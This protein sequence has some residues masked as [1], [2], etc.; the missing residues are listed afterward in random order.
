MNQKS[1]IG[2]NIKIAKENLE[3]G[4]LVAIPTETVYGLAANAFDIKAVAKI[5]EAKNRPT[6]DP[7][8]VH[9][10]NIDKIKSWT[11][12]FPSWA[13]ELGKHF[14]AGALTLLLPRK[15]IIPDLVTSGLPHVAVRIPNHSLTLELLKSL[16]FPLAAPSA[17]P[18]GYISPT[19]ANHV[20]EQLGKKVSYI[21]DGGNCKI[22]VESTI[23]GEENGQLTVFRKGGI[24]IEE[25]EKVVGKLIVKEHSNSNPH[26]DKAQD[27]NKKEEITK[28]ASSGM[29]LSHYAPK[30]KMRLGNIEQMLKEYE[31]NEVGILSFNKKYKQ[32]PLKNQFILS[33]EG[34]FS[35]AAQNLFS[36][37][38]ELDKLNIK[39]ILAEL[40]P[41]KE[42][43]RAINDRLRRAAY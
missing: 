39:I 13:E 2:S 3:K 19:T 11:T 31:I 1:I 22:G 5:F 6:F 37:M 35:E 36:Y 38:R 7:L 32:I 9:T 41:E 42:L 15:S 34:S 29:L 20:F 26:S 21:L 30:I 27:K 25:L 43:G 12:D 8:I 18:F 33:E 4:N 40:L 16:D 24:A 28:V 17:N 23:V 14:W 10:D